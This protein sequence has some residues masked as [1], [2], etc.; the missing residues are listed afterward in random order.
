[1]LLFSTDRKNFF[2]KQLVFEP[3]LAFQ[4][5]RA[6]RQSITQSTIKLENHV[7]MLFSK[8]CQKVTLRSEDKTI[9]IMYNNFAKS[10]LHY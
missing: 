3:A 1:M 8:M 4:L 5:L 9:A 10:F 2:I 6:Q 7:D